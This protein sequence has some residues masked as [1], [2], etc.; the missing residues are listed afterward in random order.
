DMFCY[1][2]FGHNEGDEPAFTQ[3]IMYQTIRSHPTTVEIYSKKLIEEG[4]VT[5]DDV[6]QMK[7]EWRAT[8]EA[9]FEAGQAYK[10]NKADWLDGA[11]SGLKKAD[12]EDEQRR[13]KTAVPVKT[14]KEIGK[15]LTE[16][17][18]DFEVHRTIR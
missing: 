3:P 17:P 5:K 4:L 8:L 7:A 11:W 6:D 15:K 18:A 1:R 10:P 9:E 2:R 16:V 14:L 13:G 12:D